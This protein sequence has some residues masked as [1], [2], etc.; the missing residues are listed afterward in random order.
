[1]LGS[2]GLRAVHGRLAHALE[3][4]GKANPETLAV[5]FRATEEDER[6]CGYAVSAAARAEDTLAFARAARLYRLA[7]DLLPEAAAE[8][9]AMGEGVAGG[10]PDPGV[11]GER[12]HSDPRRLPSRSELQVRLG[13]AL[14]SAGLSRAAADTFLRAVESGVVDPFDAQRSAAEKLLI[15]G[16][17]DRGLAVLRHVLRTVDMELVAAPWKVLVDLWLSRLR[18]R[19]RGFAFEPVREADVDPEVLRRI[20]VCWSVEAGLGLVDVLRASQFHAR[21]LHL[22]L[23]A[24]EPQ[25][26]A[27][28]LAME[29]FFGSMEGISGRDVLERARDLAGRVEGTYAASLTEMAA[30][31]L[32]CSKGEWAE[33]RE[34]LD[35]AE[36][37]LRENRR[38]VTWELDTVRQFRAVASV[39]LGR[40]RE[41]FAEMPALLEQAR[42]QD[43]LY[44]QTHLLH[45][46]ECL[47]LL[48]EGR[49]EEAERV[50][51]DGL[52]SWSREGFHFQHFGH[53]Q[54]RVQ[55]ALYR[56]RGREAWEAV[57]AAR[58]GLTASLLQRIELVLVQSLD[59][60]GRSAIALA[61]ELR[62]GPRDV[63]AARREFEALHQAAAA[64]RR[65]EAAGSVWSRSL[66][67]SLEAGLA[68][69][70]G[71]D[72]ADG[73]GRARAEAHLEAAEAGFV[74]AGMVIHQAVARRRLCM[75]RG[76]EAG[77]AAAESLLRSRSVSDPEAISGIFIPGHWQGATG[78]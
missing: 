74:R 10:E 26:V 59:L 53:L 66:A 17:I 6:A 43:D 48:V 35:Q 5:H 56:G 46:V 71:R 27:R 22:A 14:G 37:Q 3:L 55:V 52:R 41:L 31:M 25:R 20:D 45:W 49:P 64:A 67:S 63:G 61:Q 77:T 38:G 44:L 68:S 15:S 28:G 32:A 7:L 57:Q 18:L 21:H 29:V 76:D 78:E 42:E 16:H 50:V 39:S 11:E 60:E 47:R 75:L 70:V 51:A 2:A 58:P 9:G 24:G 4:T 19:L 30:G 40:W 13:R 33:A 12:A 65:L 73:E 69:I 8:E 54:A 62:R 36:R 72:R 34:R 23:R 1:G